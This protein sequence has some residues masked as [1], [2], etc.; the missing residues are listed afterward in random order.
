MEQQ[1]IGNKPFLWH[2]LSFY[3]NCG[4]FTWT[5]KCLPCEKWGRNIRILQLLV[6]CFPKAAP[7]WKNTTNYYLSFPK[8]QLQNVTNSN[9]TV[10]N[11]H[12]LALNC[13]LGKTLS[14]IPW[15]SSLVD[16]IVREWRSN[17]SRHD[18]TRHL[19]VAQDVRMKLWRIKKWCHKS[20][21]PAGKVLFCA[22]SCLSST[23]NRL[24]FVKERFIAVLNPWLP[25]PLKA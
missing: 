17:A 2:N 9:A 19:V 11:I 12:D 4:L 1:T 14:F 10:T 23:L 24:L 3:R 20:N 7:P 8:A 18:V 21:K 13:S 5:Q 15:K 22:K 16:V 25:G 6:S